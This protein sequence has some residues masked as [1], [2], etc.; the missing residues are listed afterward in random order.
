MD[1]DTSFLGTGWSFPPEFSRRGSVRMVSADEDIHQSLL[2]LLGT[3]LGER[4]MQPSFGC[5][6]RSHVYDNINASTVTVLKDLIARAILFYE[7]RVVL[8]SIDTDMA[9]AYDGRLDFRLVYHVI[10][11][12]ARHNMVYPYY[13]REGT[14]VQM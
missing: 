10:S 11:T 3:S 5:G 13:L 14:D 12:N 4:V 9:G 7:P 2:I 8:D 1:K 6:L